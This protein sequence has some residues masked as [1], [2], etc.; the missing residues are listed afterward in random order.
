MDQS[1]LLNI[2]MK[3]SSYVTSLSLSLHRP[4]HVTCVYLCFIT[5]THE[6]HHF[7]RLNSSFPCHVFPRGSF[8]RSSA[9]SSSA[10]RSFSRASRCA[11]RAKTSK[12][13]ALRRR[14]SWGVGEPARRLEEPDSSVGNWRVSTVYTCLYQTCLVILVLFGKITALWPWIFL[15][16]VW[17][18]WYIHTH[19]WWFSVLVVTLR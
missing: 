8:R 2:F 1:N 15:M 12:A 4:L 7:S 14:R 10:W 19:F 16:K 9:T 6:I 11:R 17:R 5:W 13:S 18:S 3:S